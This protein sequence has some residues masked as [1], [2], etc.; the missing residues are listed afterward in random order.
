[1]D[2]FSTLIYLWTFLNLNL[3]KNGLPT[4]PP[5]LVHVDIERH[6]CSISTLYPRGE[7]NLWNKIEHRV[8]LC[9]YLLY[10]S[11]V[12]G[13]FWYEVGLIFSVSPVSSS[14]LALLNMVRWSVFAYCCYL[15]LW[16][17]LVKDCDRKTYFITHTPRT[18]YH[19]DGTLHRI[20]FFEITTLG[21]DFYFYSTKS[22]FLSCS[23]IWAIFWQI[24]G[25]GLFWQRQYS[26]FS[27]LCFDPGHCKC[28][29]WQ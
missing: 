22:W 6:T 11:C 29:N 3:D 19:M 8:S 23:N 20:L 13:N 9:T 5:H 7:R 27:K 4:H 1:V 25:L 2:T 16:W 15:A 17:I 21:P 24:S 10:L 12:L 14:C 28:K 26:E 18:S